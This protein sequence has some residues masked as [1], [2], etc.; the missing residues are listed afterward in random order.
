MTHTLPRVPFAL[1]VLAAR[2]ACAGADAP[3]SGDE[4]ASGTLSAFQSV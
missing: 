2:G 3:P 1:L 4:P